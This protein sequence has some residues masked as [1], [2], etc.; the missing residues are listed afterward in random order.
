MMTDYGEAVA[1]TSLL[2]ISNVQQGAII[3]GTALEKRSTK[4]AENF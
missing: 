2:C 3:T 1:V 4:N